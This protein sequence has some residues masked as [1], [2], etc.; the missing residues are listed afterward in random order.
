MIK[1]VQA[2]VRLYAPCLSC[3]DGSFRFDHLKIGQ[4]VRWKCDKCGVEIYLQRESEVETSVELTGNRNIPITVT[5]KSN[6]EPPIFA[7][8]NT[9]KYVHSQDLSDEDFIDHEKYFYEE[10]TCPTNWFRDVE[11]ISVNG[12]NDPHGLFEF[13]SIEDGHFVDEGVITNE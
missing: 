13:V 12:D 3:K 5:L 11:Q 4:E 2:K 7:K 6:T 8:I 1:S 10:H 9:W